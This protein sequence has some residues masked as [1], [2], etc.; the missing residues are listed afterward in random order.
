MNLL[1]ERIPP[2][3]DFRSLVDTNKSQRKQQDGNPERENMSDMRKN[4]TMSIPVTF[5]STLRDV[6]SDS[7]VHGL[8]NMFRTRN[9]IVRFVWTCLFLAGFVC[10]IYFTYLSTIG[11]FNYEVSVSIQSINESP[12]TFP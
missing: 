12:V 3:N 10:A 2:K 5:V 7:T 4:K 1:T 9:N 8:A 11:F 6:L